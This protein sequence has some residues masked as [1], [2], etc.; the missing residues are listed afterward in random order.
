MLPI[1]SILLPFL[2]IS[3]YHDLGVNSQYKYRS[4]LS[5]ALSYYFFFFLICFWL[6]WVFIAVRGL[7]LAVAN[8]GYSVAVRRLLIAVASLCCGARALGVQ[9]SGV[10]AHGLSSCGAQA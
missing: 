7:S 8:G 2:L 5:L 1:A 4:L 3:F 9:A 10:V 6:H